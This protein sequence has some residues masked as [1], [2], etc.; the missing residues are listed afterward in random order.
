VTEQKKIFRTDGVRGVANVEPR[1]VIDATSRA[2]ETPLA[3]PTHATLPRARA[4]RA[5]EAH[6]RA[7]RYPEQ[8]E[9]RKKSPTN[10][11]R[12]GAKALKYWMVSISVSAS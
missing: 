2:P 1:A 6:W 4:R 11:T 12:P 7:Q 10:T 5:G 9:Q 8:T 3:K